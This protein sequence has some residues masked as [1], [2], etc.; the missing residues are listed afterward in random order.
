M[1]NIRQ[2]ASQL[3]NKT[4]SDI[5]I[6]KSKFCKIIKNINQNAEFKSQLTPE[7]N[8]HLKNLIELWNNNKD[9]NIEYYFTMKKHHSYINGKIENEMLKNMWDD[10]IK[11]T[12]EF[13]T[14][15]LKLNYLC[16]QLN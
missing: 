4:M 1:D 13:R 12:C 6:S 14:Q 2:E 7:M 16:N 5:K 10:Y 11:S 9:A 15:L 3:Y 8:E